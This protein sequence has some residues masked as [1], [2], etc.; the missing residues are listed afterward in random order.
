MKKVGKKQLT[1]SKKYYIILMLQAR[2]IHSSPYLYGKRLIINIIK[3]CL[4][5]CGLGQFCDAT[6]KKR[7]IS[8]RRGEGVGGPASALLG[9]RS[10]RV[11]VGKGGGDSL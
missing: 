5:L 4:F 10:V 7:L 6:L 9:L 3:L 8:G 11:M 1:I 2:V